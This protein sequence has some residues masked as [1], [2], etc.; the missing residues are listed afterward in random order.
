[1]N[2][3]YGRITFGQAA[4]LGNA[5]LADHI[6]DPSWVVFAAIRGFLINRPGWPGYLTRLAEIPLTNADQLRLNLIAG[7]T[8]GL[9]QAA[10]RL[11]PADAVARIEPTV[12]QPFDAIEEHLGSVFRYAL[13]LTRRPDLAEDVTQETLLRGLRR[14][15]KLRDYRAIRIWLFR[16]ATNVWTDQ[17]RRG[18]LFPKA[19][20]TEP[21]CPRPLPAKVSDERENVQ[22][23]LA[24]M[25]E[26]PPRQRQVLYLVTCEN[27]AHG[28]VATILE[29]NESAVKANLSL[30]RKEMRLRLKDV[31]EQ[32]CGRQ[33]SGRR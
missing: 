32:V 17:L 2:K 12:T 1:L 11:V 26:L 4:E 31:Y 13:R 10:D 14:W 16:I 21:A 15:Q 22:M 9:P 6:A 8:V 29:I 3:V 33:P 25:D 27:M 5:T 30:A 7:L 18:R 20:D 19:L 28:E 24:A 23:A